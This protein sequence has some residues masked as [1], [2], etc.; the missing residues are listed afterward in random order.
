MT[1]CDTNILVYAYNTAS[2][3]H[4][5]ALRFLTENLTNPD[6]AIS[7]LILVEFYVLVRNA[8][9]FPKPL[10]SREAALLVDELRSNRFWTVLK[11]TSDV[12]DLIWG[13]CASSEL[14]RRAVF[15]AC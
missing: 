9:L 5:S 13:A 14:P 12:S 10:S 1:S 4:P 2:P 6:F 3:E 7:E 11:D 15:D 8:A